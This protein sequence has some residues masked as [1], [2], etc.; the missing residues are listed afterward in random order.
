M[1]VNGCKQ[2]EESVLGPEDTVEAFCRAIAGGNMSQACQL[3]DTSAMKNYL[4]CW[5]EKWNELEAKDSSALR[6]AAGIL[7]ESLFSVEKTE[8][9]GEKRVVT[10]TLE[11]EGESKTCR[12]VLRKEEGEWRLEALTDVQ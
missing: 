4:D 6:V 8:K 5:Q 7:S 9:E 3:C 2:Q 11:S 1:T 12:A 10:Y